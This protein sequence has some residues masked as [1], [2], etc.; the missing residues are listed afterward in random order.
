MEEW[1]LVLFV[2]LLVSVKRE[3]DHAARLKACYKKI[4][5]EVFLSHCD[6]LQPLEK[7]AN[8]LRLEIADYQ[9]KLDARDQKI[10]ALSLDLEEKIN[11]VQQLNESIS[12]LKIHILK[13]KSL[14]S[15]EQDKYNSSK[16][17]C[18]SLDESIAEANSHN[19]A[20]SA[21]LRKIQEQ[22]QEKQV[23][24]KSLRTSYDDTV[25]KILQTKAKK[26]QILETLKL[27]ENENDALNRA[28]KDG[29]YKL[30][31]V[32]ELY[33]PRILEFESEFRAQW[34]PLIDQLRSE[35]ETLRSTII[36]D[37][38]KYESLLFIK[39]PTL[40]TAHLARETLAKYESYKA[41]LKEEISA[42]LV[43]YNY[44][45][46]DIDSSYDSVVHK[47]HMMVGLW[48][49]QSPLGQAQSI[50]EN[51]KETSK[52]LKANLFSDLNIR[53]LASILNDSSFLSTINQLRTSSASTNSG[54]EH[55]EG[56]ASADDR[57]SVHT[58]DTSVD[59]GEARVDPV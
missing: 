9:A 39:H 53:H 16:I 19:E 30:K 8:D 11:T 14:I 43:S 21:Q 49:S 5:D 47:F 36:N 35:S 34:T 50:G 54:I 10:D 55:I 17:D 46:Q 59:G 4:Q 26:V 25:F 7:Q 52:L 23:Q 48:L 3:Q 38:T 28:I 56:V 45:I 41:L 20:V 1:L 42:R 33:L 12:A 37:L 15:V 57:A 44:M 32:K 29:N 40:E 31:K 24:N 58:N 27:K 22:I 51:G 6:L 13:T 18:T 2:T